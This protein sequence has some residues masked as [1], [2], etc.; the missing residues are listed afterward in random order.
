MRYV[1]VLTPEPDGSAWNV[2]VPALP[3]CLTWGETPEE[4]I[5]NAREAIAGHVAA[6]RDFGEPVPPGDAAADAPVSL[7]LDVNEPTAV[8]V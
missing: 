7:V 2:T 1:V 5:A 8:P 3:G 4:A 6:L